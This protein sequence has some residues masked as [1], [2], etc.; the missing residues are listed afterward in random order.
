MPPRRPPTWRSAPTA[1]CWPAAI[2]SAGSTCGPLPAGGTRGPP[3]APPPPVWTPPGTPPPA[4]A[5]LTPADR[6]PPSP[7]PPPPVAPDRLHTLSR[8]LH[9]RLPLLG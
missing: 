1:P 4:P 9:S 5:T 8:R 7:Q 6:R 3:P 2:P